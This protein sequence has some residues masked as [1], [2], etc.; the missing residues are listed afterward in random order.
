MGETNLTPK[1][2]IEIARLERRNRRWCD[3]FLY[4][5]IGM[6]A[7]ALPT[8]GI[9]YFMDTKPEKS[10]ELRS[11]EGLYSTA[12]VL[13]QMDYSKSD[14]S[15]EEIRGVEELKKH[16]KLIRKITE[17]KRQEEL[18]R[19]GQVIES[20]KEVLKNLCWGGASLTV[21]LSCGVVGSL[22]MEGRT[23]EQL[24]TYRKQVEGSE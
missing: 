12:S 14:L 21:L 16:A 1:Q 17:Q 24:S 3:R 23:R 4:G 8:L 7:V 15:P 9:D 20:R 19:Y 10:S 6:V 11:L 5:I 18:A 2:A 13:G 22:V